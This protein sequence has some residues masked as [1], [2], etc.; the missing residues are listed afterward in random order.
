MERK[1]ILSV[2]T[3]IKNQ[4]VGS[5]DISVLLSWGIQNFAASTFKDMAT[6]IFEVNGRLFQGHV[7]ICYNT[8]DF[9]ETYLSDKNGIR[10]I[11]DMAYFNN[12]GEIIDTAIESGT[13]KEEYNNF[14]L[15]E[16]I[17]LIIGSY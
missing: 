6:L 9:Y 1:E 3:T 14:C 10:C 15:G 2:A 5:M 4:L 7:L 12:L 11:C 8:L 17:R 13:N 16:K